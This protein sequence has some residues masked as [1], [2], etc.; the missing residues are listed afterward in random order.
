MYKQK[1]RL[2]FWNKRLFVSACLKP[3]SFQ[4]LRQTVF[5][6][7]RK[8]WPDPKISSTSLPDDPSLVKRCPVV[9]NLSGLDALLLHS[10]LFKIA[11]FYKKTIIEV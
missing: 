10:T 1:R 5:K 7:L 9:I 11:V 4:Q 3:V 6:P 8:I 2:S